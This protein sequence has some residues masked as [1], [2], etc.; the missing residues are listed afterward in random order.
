VDLSA[1]TYKLYGEGRFWAEGTRAAPLR[2]PAASSAATQVE[3]SMNFINMSRKI[4]DDIL[5]MKQVNYRFVGES[6]VAL[7]Q[8][9]VIEFNRSFHLP[10]DLN[11][12]SEVVK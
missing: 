9:N 1:F 2:V 6:L 10:F 11:G 7:P 8:L 12:K 5:A 4:F 3:L